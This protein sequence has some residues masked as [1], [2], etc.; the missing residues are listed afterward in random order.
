MGQGG[1]RLPLG[2]KLMTDSWILL[3]ASLVA[4]AERKSESVK[5]LS[6]MS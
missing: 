6:S 4:L 1:L 3:S 5:A 2:K